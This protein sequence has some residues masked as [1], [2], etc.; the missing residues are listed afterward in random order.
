MPRDSQ[1]VSVPVR[2]LLR[3]LG[4]SDDEIDEAAETGATALIAL[5]ARGLLT[6]EKPEPE[7]EPEPPREPDAP[8]EPLTKTDEDAIVALLHSIGASDD[9]IKRARDEG[10]TALFA[11]AADRLIVPGVERLTRA[12]VSERSGIPESEAQTYWRAMGFADVSDDDRAFTEVDVDMLRLLKNLMQSGFI[13][14]DAALQMTRV[15]GR[16]MASVA[17][18]QLDLVRSLGGG[19]SVQEARREAIVALVQARS[20]L[21]DVIERA[22]V[23][24][25][26]R[27]LA[28]EAKRAAVAIDSTGGDFIVGFA[29]LVGFTALSAQ[30]DETTLASAVS[31][32]E[33]TAVETVAGLSGRVVKMIGDEV[34]FEA[35]SAADGIEIALR[36]VEAFAADGA[37]PDIRAGLAEGPA[38]GYQGDLFGP[39]P[40]L[41]HRLVEVAYPATVLVSAKIHDALEEDPRFEFTAVRPQALKGFGR[42]R[43]W[44]VRRRPA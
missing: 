6:R 4:A 39:A 3:T 17:A 40:N 30:M 28:D 20:A 35:L 5:G 7:H 21:L 13:D 14:R 22:L 41:A 31:K 26:R 1:P 11:L 29:D 19:L 34:M 15:M 25:W 32:F 36:L 42:T 27:H 9:E 24:M 16:A 18:A 12:E 38:T 8:P 44:R 43:F 37:L 23:Y 33:E 10:S 2:E